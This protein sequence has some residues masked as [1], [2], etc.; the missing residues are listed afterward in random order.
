VPRLG[1]EWVLGYFDDGHVLRGGG[2]GRVVEQPNGQ[3]RLVHRH[4]CALGFSELE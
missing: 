1:D 2:I 3:H 4:N